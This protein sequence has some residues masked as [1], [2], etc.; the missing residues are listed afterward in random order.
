MKKSILM[1]PV[2]LFTGLLCFSQFNSGSKFISG[3]TSFNLDYSGQRWKSDESQ[4]DYAHKITSMSFTPT[5]GYFIKNRLAI[6]GMSEFYCSKVKTD[7]E[8]YATRSFLI[9]PLVRYYLNY[10][11]T[12]LMPFAEMDAGIGCLTE[13]YK[14]TDDGE[15]ENKDKYSLYRISAGAGLN[16]FLNESIAFETSLKYY[17]RSQNE[18]D[19][20]NNEKLINNGIL[21]RFGLIF[22]FSSI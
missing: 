5:A 11:Y 12:G 10:S 3:T 1:I 13:M 20:V 15:N 2:F 16:F 14:Y 4:S 21:F 17:I 8:T 7:Y 6:G 22:F 18:K 19:S 9:G